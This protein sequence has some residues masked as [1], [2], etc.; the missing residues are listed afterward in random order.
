VI[1]PV[2]LDLVVKRPEHLGDGALL[3]E[4]RDEDLKSVCCTTI[5][6]WNSRSELMWRISRYFSR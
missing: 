6:P 1:L 5:K 2:R 4:G 3:G